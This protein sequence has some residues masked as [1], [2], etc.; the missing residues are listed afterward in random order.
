M[1]KIT[2]FDKLQKEL[3]DA[4]RAIEDLDGDLGSVRF[5]PHDPASIERA[6]QDVGRLVDDRV[7]VYANNSI[8]GPLAIQMKEKYRAAILERAAEARAKPEED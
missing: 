8:V 7:G 6:I 5:D 2:G 1:M 3:S 4:Q